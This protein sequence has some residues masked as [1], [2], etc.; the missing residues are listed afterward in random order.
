M[1]IIF[2][3]VQNYAEVSN[4]NLL[5]NTLSELKCNLLVDGLRNLVFARSNNFA[6]IL[7]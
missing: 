5:E 2:K 7:F 4:I 3:F 6:G 1:E